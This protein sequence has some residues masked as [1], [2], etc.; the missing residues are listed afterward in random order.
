MYS[1]E[2][3]PQCFG[4][5]AMDTGFQT[6][7]VIYT[8]NWARLYEMPGYIYDIILMADKEC[9]LEESIYDLFE[10]CSLYDCT[11]EKQLEND[12]SMIFQITG[13]LNSVGAIYY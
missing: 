4:E 13:I 1:F 8:M 6:Y 5:E 10:F 9:E 12:V 2:N 3:K 11:I 7:L